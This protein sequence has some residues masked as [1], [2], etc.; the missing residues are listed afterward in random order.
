MT[1]VVLCV[2]VPEE[3]KGRREC[4]GVA[5]V[6][7]EDGALLS[8]LYHPHR[9]HGH[10]GLVLPTTRVPQHVPRSGK[11]GVYGLVLRDQ[12]LFVGGWVGK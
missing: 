4:G 3:R 11:G 10:R 5:H 8:A 2:P 12:S 6:P 9:R 7:D 1:P